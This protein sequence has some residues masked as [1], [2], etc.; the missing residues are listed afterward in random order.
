MT[1][2][3][4]LFT[5][6]LGAFAIGY[7]KF[8]ALGYISEVIY[9]PDD[10][11][12]II[13]V[14]GSIMTIGPV[15]AFAL[16]APLA[17]SFKKSQIMFTT[18]FMTAIALVIGYF[19]NWAGSSWLYLFIIGTLMGIYS[20]AKMSA[21]P[22]EAYKSGRTTDSVNAGLSIVF[23][24]GMLLGIASG[25]KAYEWN[26]TKG[27]WIGIMV[28]AMCAIPA[29]FCKYPDEKSNSFSNSFSELISD[30]LSLS[31]KY[32]FFLLSGPLL[33]GV[34]SAVSLAVTAYANQVNLGSLSKCSFMPLF[35]AIGI[36]FGSLIS[37]KFTK[38]RFSVAFFSALGM[39]ISIIFIPIIIEY[40]IKNNIMPLNNLYLVVACILIITGFFFGIATNLIDSELLF[41][42]GRDKKE[43]T[44]AALQSIF[45]AF[46]SFIVG[47]GIGISILLNW[48]SSVSQFIALSAI[49]WFAMCAIICLGTMEGTMNNIYSKLSILFIKTILPLRYKIK[50]TGLSKLESD[51]GILVLPNHPAEVDPLILTSFLW[52]KCPLRPVVTES[53]FYKAG[54]NQLFK[55]IRAFPMPDMDTGSGFY[56]KLR[57]EKILNNISQGLDNGDNILIY[58]AGQLVRGGEEKLKG[59]SGTYNIIKNTKDCKIVFVV[60]RG[61]WGSSFS[62][63][64]TNGK[65]PDLFLALKNGF[66]SVLKNLI[67]FTPRREVSI[68]IYEAPEGFH[69][70]SNKEQN[71]IM[72]NVYHQTE[73]V[74]TPKLIPYGIWSKKLPK[75]EEINQD[76]KITSLDDLD[77]EFIE[78]TR[79]KLAE[80]LKVDINELSVNKNLSEDLG[81]DSLSKADVAV[82][83]DDEYSV[84]VEELPALQTVADVISLAS[85]KDD[86]LRDVQVETTPEEWIKGEDFRT[87]PILPKAD[88]IV[89]AFLHN[90]DTLGNSAAIADDITGVLTWKKL[91]ITVLLLSKIFREYPDKNI[92]IMLP[93]SNGGAIAIMSVLLAGKTPVMINWTTGQKNIEHIAQVAELNII[94]TSGR[95]LDKLTN[96]QFGSIVDKFVFFEDIKQ[97]IGLGEKI[98]AFLMARKKADKLI[99][100]LDLNEIKADDN[101]VVLFTSGSESAPKGV[102]LTHKNILSNIKSVF[103]LFDFKK[104]D[105]IYGFLPPFHSFGFTVTTMLPLCTGLKVAYYPNPTEGQKISAG[106]AKW[107][108]SFLCGTPTFFNAI[109]K[110]GKDNLKTI[111]SFVAGAEKAPESLFKEVEALGE[112]VHLYEGYGITECSPVLTIH[113]PNKIAEGVGHPLPGI[114]L[115]IVDIDDNKKSLKQGERGLILA[116]GLNIFS[117]YLHLDKN[118]F[119][120]I[121]DKK[122]YNTGDLGYLTENGNLIL[123]GRMKRFIKIAGEMISLPA[124]EAALS[125]KWKATEEGPVT[126]IHADEKSG[127]RPIIHLI[128][129]QNLDLSEVNKYLKE[130]GFSNLSK[131]GN[132]IEV[133]EIPIL[134]TGKID[135]QGLKKLVSK[136][137][138]RKQGK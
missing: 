95:F 62:T 90:C 92:G 121:D 116:S 52:N 108:I 11:A 114:E 32:P 77:K 36:I 38:R 87:E 130:Y 25:A 27:S 111:K 75:Q 55:L 137:T 117:G 26:I 109:I 138:S 131:I 102:P 122:Y 35:A 100:S 59:A 128:T 124:I 74:E 78:H 57:I 107:K 93:A 43:G 2:I 61:L 73:R 83:L 3:Y 80:F 1:Y 101:A 65:T 68:E 14:I 103:P 28:F 81:L 5:A 6:M 120:I 123:A 9:T 60:T 125:A 50:I 56:K 70:L 88:T 15:L 21:V 71:D 99:K 129:T 115:L 119:V 4:L 20:V 82:W 30:S 89:K 7:S 96:V 126:A 42:A 66:V 94:L 97:N 134:G 23:I 72:E 19:S 29:L 54:I 136:H 37:T 106:C 58:P 69:K 110:K 51:K 112:G 44:G 133:S 41:R 79:I 85:N 47:G 12:W 63:Y 49:V 31:F 105:A 48:L 135:Y 64:L 132:I 53:F 45:V 84:S 76:L 67:F 98:A 104:T 8:F 34:A 17:S 40:S 118:P 18:S 16:S 22:L 13:Q 39:S 127:E 91:K 113:H 33:W 86:N 24:V 46:F 10:R